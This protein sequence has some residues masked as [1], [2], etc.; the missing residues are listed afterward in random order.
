MKKRRTLIISLLL[1]AALALGIGYATTTGNVKISGEVYNKPHDLELVFVSGVKTAT[2][3][4]NDTAF[5]AS[6]V[7][8]TAGSTSAT[9]NVKEIAHDGDFVVATFVVKNNNLYDVTVADTPSIEYTGTRFYDVTTNWAL[10]QDQ[11]LTLAHNEE[12]TFTVKVTMNKTTAEELDG[13]FVITV[14]ATSAS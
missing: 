8:C 6:E 4:D 14:N 7:I 9:F 5:A 1:V 2:E 12:L 11:D 13:D 10:N 3:G